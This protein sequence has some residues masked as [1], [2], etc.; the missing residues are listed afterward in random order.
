MCSYERRHRERLR[1]KTRDARSSRSSSCSIHSI[2]TSLTLQVHPSGGPKRSQPKPISACKR[3]PYPYP[4]AVRISF[5]LFLCWDRAA[6]TAPDRRHREPLA[7]VASCLRTHSRP[8]RPP[9]SPRPLHHSRPRRTS[10]H[11]QPSTS[12]ASSGVVF[13]SRTPQRRGTSRRPRSRTRA[14]RSFGSPMRMILLNRC[15]PTRPADVSST[16]SSARHASIRQSEGTDVH[17]PSHELQ[18][19]TSSTEPPP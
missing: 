16:D 14:R 6:S 2:A 15:V 1:H 12:S 11:L 18:P 4:L 10:P 7:R 5:F 13:P 17:Y 9:K 3:L 19:P 8:P